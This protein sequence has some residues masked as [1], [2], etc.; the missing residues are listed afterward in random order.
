MTSM[1]LAAAL[2]RVG[3][4]YRA[5]GARAST[6]AALADT[7]RRLM[8][9]FRDE[10]GRDPTLDDFTLENVEDWSISLLAEYTDGRLAIESVRSHVRRIRAESAR[11]D[12]V[13][14]TDDHRLAALRTPR[15][16]QADELRV[17]TLEEVGRLV[18]AADRS[19]SSGRLDGALVAILADAGARRREILP[20]LRDD[21]RPDGPWVAIRQ[22][23]KD[24]RRRWA[25]LGQ[26]GN[27]LVTDYLGRRSSGL[28]FLATGNRPLSGDAVK[29]RLHRLSLKAELERP[30]GAQLLRRFAATQLAGMGVS[31]PVLYR[32][33]GWTPDPRK[34]A[35]PNYVNL[36]PEQLAEVYRRHSPLDQLVL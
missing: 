18:S 21:Y 12:A 31:D 1:N 11:A 19:T 8:A 9:Y 34:V 25:M 16:A 35:W 4:S 22:P 32:L 29:N 17:P 5:S 23:A 24:G 33:L 30:I 15:R 20:M 14:L 7:N 26:L 27:E 6:L 3:R 28:L 36:A 2:E 10:L 13:G